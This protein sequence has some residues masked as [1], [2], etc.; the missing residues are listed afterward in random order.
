MKK[1]ILGILVCVSIFISGCSGN[2]D[3]KGN[4]VTNYFNG[5]GELHSYSQLNRTP[6]LYD[7]N[8]KY[9]KKLNYYCIDGDNAYSICTDAFIRWRMGLNSSI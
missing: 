8:C 5:T 1:Y 9:I 6:V 2:K 3:N 7:D 4:L